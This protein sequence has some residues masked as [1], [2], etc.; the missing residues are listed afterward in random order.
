M[1]ERQYHVDGDLVPASEA[2]VHVSD[3][4]FK[5][6]DA[7]F[8]TVR[9]YG[10]T[11]FRWDAHLDRLA[12]TCEILSLD[13]GLSRANLRSRVAAVLDANDLADASIRLSITRGPDTGGIVPSEE[14]DPTVVVTCRPLPRGGRES[15]ST[16][17]GPAT[18]QTVKTRRPP[19]RAL[20]SKAKTHNY[21]NGV[22]AGLEL[23]VTG[24][25]EAL[26]LDM[27]GSVAEGTTSNCFF[28]DDRALHTPS[29][30]GPVLPGVTRDVVL[31]LAQSEGLPVRTGRYTPDDF[32]SADEV[33]LTSSTREI[34]PVGTV[35][36]IDVDGGPVTPLLSRLYDALVERECYAVE[37]A[38]ESGSTGDSETGDDPSSSQ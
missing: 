24:A 21:L 28:V 29:L 33:F 6:G 20:P 35:D 18:L 1:T 16:W 14:I 25:D 38:D 2:T 3:R 19:D 36:G 37:S 30:E 15:E 31:D 12:D 13:H 11:L 17:D 23:R 32:R 4:G 10:G 8:E 34:R 5:Y 9:V 26:I 7:A 27:D 22:L